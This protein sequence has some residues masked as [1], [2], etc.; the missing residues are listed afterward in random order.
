MMADMYYM[1]TAFSLLFFVLIVI[2]S[3]YEYIKTD[4][5]GRQWDASVFIVAPLCIVNMILIVVLAYESWNIEHIDYTTSPA[6]IYVTSLSYFA[7]VF[8]GLFL[9]NVAMLVKVVFKFFVESFE[10]PK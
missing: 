5:H 1:L 4:K 10:E 6:S 8:F 3:E 7:V 9:I 2:F